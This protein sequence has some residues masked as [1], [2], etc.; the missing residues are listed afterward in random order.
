VEGKESLE[1][2]DI[3]KNTR[4]KYRQRERDREMGVAKLKLTLISTGTRKRP[5]SS[6]TSLPNHGLSK[7]EGSRRRG[8]F[9]F[10]FFQLFKTSLHI[11]VHSRESR[12]SFP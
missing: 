10:A 7:D 3:S 9:I 8:G 5:H 4:K 1:S 11:V 2:L 6:Y 12:R